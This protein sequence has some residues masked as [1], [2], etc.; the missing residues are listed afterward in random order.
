MIFYCATV[1]MHPNPQNNLHWYLV[2]GWLAA[3]IA[4]VDGI[5]DLLLF[6]LFCYKLHQLARLRVEH[7]F[8]S[9]SIGS[10][11]SQ[12]SNSRLLDVI[13]KQTIIGLCVVIFNAGFAFAQFIMDHFSTETPQNLTIV[14][15]VRAVQGVIISMLL[16]LGLAMNDAEYRRVCGCC[17][18]TFHDIGSN[19]L[20]RQITKEPPMVNIGECVGAVI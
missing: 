11:L 13:T 5:L 17:H 10:A 20:R 15:S 19:N 14:Y 6:A 3:C 18:R 9:M 16:Y 4:A 2:L 12:N 1:G 7:D 8:R